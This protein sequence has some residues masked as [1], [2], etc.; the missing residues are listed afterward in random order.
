MVAAG[1]KVQPPQPP[2]EARGDL[3]A[4]VNGSRLYVLNRANGDLLYQRQIQ[5]APGSGP[6]P[7]SKR[8][9]VPMVTGMMTAYQFP[10]GRRLVR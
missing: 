1:G 4:V 9:F 3:V 10:S 8:A 6:A 5:D 7:N 2:L